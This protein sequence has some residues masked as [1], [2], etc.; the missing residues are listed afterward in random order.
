MS[1]QIKQFAVNNL[2]YTRTL[3][4]GHPCGATLDIKTDINFTCVRVA[5]CLCSST[6]ITANSEDESSGLTIQHSIGHATS[7]LITSND[8]DSKPEI[9]LQLDYQSGHDANEVHGKIVNAIVNHFAKHWPTDRQLE[10][11]EWIVKL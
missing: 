6:I 8:P 10:F 3:P 2:R 9:I 1:I 4:V 5:M 7:V 11:K